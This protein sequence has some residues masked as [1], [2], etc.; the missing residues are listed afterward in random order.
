[1]A[2]PI[3]TA[4]LG[5]GVSGRVFHTPLLAADPDY[6]LT[7]VVTG[8]PERAARAAERHPGA[9]IVPS[10]DDL[11]TLLDTGELELDLVI[12]G[13]PPGTHFDQAVAAINRGLHV[14]V[15]KPFVPTAIQGEELVRRAQEAGV[16]T[17]DGEWR[18]SDRGIW[19]P[20]CGCGLRGSCRFGRDRT[21]WGRLGR[22]PGSA[23][24][25]RP[26]GR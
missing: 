3:R 8:N 12:L 16:V 7:A 2:A 21:G 24:P 13:T 20:W 23:R 19:R 17:V 4:V 1:M 10:D 9:R 14:V 15:D 22:R 18:C 25:R 6:E 11:F 5:Y 26:A